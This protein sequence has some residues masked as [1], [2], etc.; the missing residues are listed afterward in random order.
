M[1]T[2]PHGGEELPDLDAERG[3][4]PRERLD[5]GVPSPEFNVDEVLPREARALREDLE[6]VSAFFSED[7]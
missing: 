2:W 5:R 1:S 6:G 7:S 4:D 3:R